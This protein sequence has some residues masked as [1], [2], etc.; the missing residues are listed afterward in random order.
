MSEG[1]RATDVA[2][3]VVEADEVVEGSGGK[4]GRTLVLLLLALLL[5]GGA[6]W[7][8][9]LRPAA[10]EEE[11]EPGE[12][13]ALEAIQVNLAGNHYL[14]VGIALQATTEV[15][16]E[17]DGSKAL[18]ATIELFTGRDKDDLARKPYRAKLKKALVHELE[19]AYHGEVM[20]VYFTDFVT[21]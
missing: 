20:G 12:V 11:P 19:E 6:A 14:R 9:M 4:R 16:H 1:R 8:F 21:Q 2:P 3:A 7:W 17:L 10:A 5:A 18:D 13:L 15:E